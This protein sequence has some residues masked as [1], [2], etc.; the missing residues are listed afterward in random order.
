MSATFFISDLHLSQ[1]STKLN[2]LFDVFIEKHLKEGDLLYILG[3]FFDVWLGDD[4]I[5]AWESEMAFKLAALHDR[6][7][8]LYMMRGNRDFLLGQGFFTHAK[9]IYLPDPSV[10]AL[11]GK[12][13][14]LKHGDDLCILDKKH[15]RFRK[16]TRSPWVQAL[17]ARLPLRLRKAIAQKIRAHSTRE[18]QRKPS[19]IMDVPLEAVHAQLRKEIS[20]LI[21]GHIH[22]AREMHFMLEGHAYFYRV[23][24]AWGERGNFLRVSQDGFSFEYF[25][26]M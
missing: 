12:K 16:Y 7:I 11:Y 9:C 4:A 24:D 5:S 22:K 13:I 20:G 26:A 18:C 10:I 25:E 23:L 14:L 1:E 6:G 21:H 3:D 8:S 2:H 19:K 17:F 15:Q